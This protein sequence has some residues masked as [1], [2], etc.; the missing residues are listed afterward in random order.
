[1]CS[2]WYS[3]SKFCYCQQKLCIVKHLSLCNRSSAPAGPRVQADKVVSELVRVSRRHLFLSISLKPH[4]KVTAP[5]SLAL[6]PPAG[7]WRE[8]LAPVLYIQPGLQ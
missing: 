6:W 1:M 8:C 7:A 2:C 4:T 5:T 3:N